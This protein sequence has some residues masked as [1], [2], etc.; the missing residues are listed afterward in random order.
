MQRACN[1]LQLE[2]NVLVGDDDT[3][4]DHENECS[5]GKEQICVSRKENENFCRAK[6][7]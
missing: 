1:F 4:I 2:D 6:M 7:K 5:I 3:D